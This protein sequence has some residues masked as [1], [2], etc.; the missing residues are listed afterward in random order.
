MGQ[1]CKYR[2]QWAFCSKAPLNLSKLK[3][4]ILFG[5]LQLMFI[6][7]DNIT[8]EENLPKSR[9]FACKECLCSITV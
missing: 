7:A 5:F 4:R 8:F 2:F 1:L 6:A 3:E 9:I